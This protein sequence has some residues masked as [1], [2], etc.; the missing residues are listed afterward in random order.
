VVIP[1]HNRLD[2][3]QRTVASIMRQTLTG[4]EAIVVDDGSS[5]GTARWLTE[6]E[7]ESLSAVIV[8]EHGGATRARN[9]G[10][11]RARADFVLFLDDDDLLLPSALKR[12]HHVLASDPGAIGSVG[13]VVQFDERGN[14]R[15]LRWPR[16]TLKRVVWTDVLAWWD[17]YVQQALWRTDVI[18]AVGGWNESIAFS[19]GL[20]LMRRVSRLGPMILIPELVVAYR[21]HGGQVTGTVP[22]EARRA[23]EEVWLQEHIRS[24]PPEERALAERVAGAYRVWRSGRDAYADL[25]CREGLM[26][27]LR[28]LRA[29]P[30]LLRSP[31]LRPVA[32]DSVAKASMGALI[33]KRGL[34]AVR[35]TRDSLR[36]SL[37][38]S[39]GR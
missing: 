31:L 16:R 33:G 38:R 6:R 15:K 7:D 1:T 21:M 11:E 32:I 3:L 13:R 23:T 37:K 4:W 10:L 28:A 18:R 2:L 5:D 24:L 12:L 30:F 34:S 14:R 36:R 35:N 9:I 20:E 19:E 25:D 22:R 8:E 27:Y 17:I 26:L 39:V 29:A